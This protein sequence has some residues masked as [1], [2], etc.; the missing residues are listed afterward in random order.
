MKTKILL[1]VFFYL[2]AS[3]IM[4]AQFSFSNL[5]QGM[6]SDNEA[7]PEK[8]SDEMKKDMVSLVEKNSVLESASKSELIKD[9]KNANSYADVENA[10]VKS[11]LKEEDKDSLKAQA[12]DI[13]SKYKEQNNA[14]GDVSLRRFFPARFN[15]N[16]SVVSTYFFEGKSDYTQIFQNN[17]VV[18][19]P[20]LKNLSFNSEVVN[21]YLGP[22]RVGIGFQFSST[23]KDDDSIAAADVKKDKLVAS[24]QNGGGNL[25]VNIQYPFI[26]IGEESDSFGFKSFFY[27]NSGVEL[28]K[29]NEAENDFVLTNNTGI[30]LG[31][32]GNGKKSKISAFLMA[33]GSVLYGNSKYNKILAA[34]EDFKKALLLFNLGL[35]INFSD[36]YTVKAEFYTGGEYIKRNFPATIS[37]VIVPKK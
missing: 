2:A 23:V 13:L 26:A 17:N 4:Q 3:S 22:L 34:D 1:L 12:Y 18:Y 31:A 19:N 24:L 16:G 10:I 9:V 28:T 15:E 29:I 35:G 27:H 37:F 36:M 20:N 32:F 8:L 25:F 14:E 7:V 21:D 6:R 33:K 5:K 30:T 11:S